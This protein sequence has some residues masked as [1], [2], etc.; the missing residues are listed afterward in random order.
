MGKRSHALGTPKGR[1]T[2]TCVTLSW[3]EAYFG[4]WTG[5]QRQLHALRDGLS[6]S[7]GCDHED[8][9]T[10]HI[11]GASAELAV[12]KYYDRYWEPRINTFKTKADVSQRY[13]VRWR[14]KPDYELII[15]QNDPDDHIAILVFGKSPHFIIQGFYPI[16]EAKNH[17]EW[18][19]SPNNRPPA[20]FIPNS[21]L[22][23]LT[24]DFFTTCT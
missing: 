15:R 10:K 11:E 3:F 20:W 19:K 13:E 21:S 1:E 16:G 18:F 23:E 2:M 9:W 5:V 24:P 12:A 7:H 17:Q 8:S 22:R 6:D 14:S 4:A